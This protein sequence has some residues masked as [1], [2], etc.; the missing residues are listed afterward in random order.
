M[1][2]PSTEISEAEKTLLAE[3][4]RLAE[5]KAAA[6]AEAARDADQKEREEFELRLKERD[7]ARTKKGGVGR[8]DKDAPDLA[9]L[10]QAERRKA[11]AKLR[12]TS[13]QSYLVKRQEKIMQLEELAVQDEEYL[14]NNEELTQAERKIH[15]LDKKFLDLAKQHQDVHKEEEHT[16]QIPDGG[17]HE[18]G[19]VD[20]KKQMELLTGGRYEEE[21]V[22]KSEQDA[23]MEE[24]AAN[25]MMEVGAKDKKKHRK[26]RKGLEKEAD[27]YDLLLEDQIDFISQAVMGGENI[28]DFAAEEEEDPLVKAE[29][30]RKKQHMSLQEVRRSL[31]VFPYREEL[32]EA[33]AENQVLVV[34]G[35]TGS[36]KTTQIP[37]YL[38]E[39]GYS[40]L[41]IIGCTQPRRVAAM[42]VAARVA[43]EMGVKLGNEVDLSKAGPIS[44]LKELSP[45]KSPGKATTPTSTDPR[46]IGPSSGSRR[47]QSAP[48]LPHR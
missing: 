22:F 28:E 19:K 12:E 35:E 1:Q 15:K 43:E 36:G 17:V 11:L 24:Q 40:K 7:E 30:E 37:Q 41:G 5:E 26:K 42:S 46:R 38:A 34:V 18:E 20:R 44:K 3:E 14:F 29:K 23:W 31:P 47:K 33:I 25:A 45:W 8:E 9:S 39:V 32:L 48:W 27:E 2:V 13:R 10:P 21:E 6:E 4:E 16:Y